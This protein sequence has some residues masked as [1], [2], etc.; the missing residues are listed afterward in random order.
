MRT[1]SSSQ[2]SHVTPPPGPD[3]VGMGQGHGPPTPLTLRPTCSVLPYLAF[4]IQHPTI[5]S[6]PNVT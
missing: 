5:G 3:K 4:P 6:S 1:L 2:G